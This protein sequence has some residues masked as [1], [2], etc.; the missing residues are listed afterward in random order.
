MGYNHTSTE[1]EQE[2]ILRAALDVTPSNWEGDL[3][4]LNYYP[5]HY[6]GHIYSDKKEF[7]D[8]AFY[9]E[10]ALALSARFFRNESTQ[11]CLPELCEAY[12]MQDN[13]EKA[14]LCAF[15]FFTDCLKYIED[16]DED[17][18]KWME[19]LRCLRTP[20]I[21][22]VCPG[23]AI[24]LYKALAPSINGRLLVKSQYIQSIL[25]NSI[26]YQLGRA[27]LLSG[28]G[29]QAHQTFV[30]ILHRLSDIPR[31]DEEFWLILQC[32]GHLSVLN[33][34]SV[35]TGVI[36]YEQQIVELLSSGLS[37]KGRPAETINSTRI[38]DS[39]A[40]A[41]INQMASLEEILTAKMKFDKGATGNITKDM[42]DLT[43]NLREALLSEQLIIKQYG[44]LQ[45]AV[46]I[47]EALY[48]P[49]DLLVTKA[50][51]M[52]A[53]ASYQMERFEDALSLW[54]E[55]LE[56]YIQ[57]GYVKISYTVQYIARCLL[58]LN[59]HEEFGIL[60]K[61]FTKIDWRRLQRREATFPPRNLPHQ[62]T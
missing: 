34:I 49:A 36:N 30:E 10:Q 43:F 54:R 52:M 8:A 1:T 51:N 35:E 32:L 42:H 27:L 44:E 53:S 55:V 6:L 11:R 37:F 14:H 60:K 12:V 23:F 47:R 13:L 56:A 45:N 15:N 16:L 62:I 58:R 17:L 31:G 61:Q 59:R 9:L 48:G 5:L 50:K 38:L 19:L 57:K 28:Q 39:I 2:P 33:K 29:D 40:G 7:K 26:S 24:E 46:S 25:Y 3:A 22:G 4:V 21:Q 18:W 41:R 20:L